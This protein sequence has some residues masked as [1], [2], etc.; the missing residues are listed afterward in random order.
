MPTAQE[1]ESFVRTYGDTLFPV[2]LSDYL[3]DNNRVLWGLLIRYA[4]QRLERL[5][6]NLTEA[7]LEQ[8]N[9]P[10][11]CDTIAGYRVGARAVFP[12]LSA[13]ADVFL[14]SQECLEFSADDVKA[15]VIHELCHWYIDSTLQAR[16]PVR[17]GDADRVAGAALHRRT[18]VAQE[19]R[20]KHTVGFCELLCHV[21]ALAVSASLSFE[22]QQGLVDASMRYDVQGGFRGV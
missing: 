6:G 12:N 10:D 3:R 5:F 1:V 2:R 7:D 11:V 20:T 17:L 18:D 21:S 9:Q 4:Q 13:A 16:R 8:F 15:L 14:L 19:R 22:N